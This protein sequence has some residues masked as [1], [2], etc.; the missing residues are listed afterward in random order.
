MICM[1]LKIPLPL[2]FSSSEPL[3]LSPHKNRVNPLWVCVRPARDWLHVALDRAPEPPRGLCGGIGDTRPQVLGS[4]RAEEVFPALNCGQGL[5]FPP[6][7]GWRAA[8]EVS[9]VP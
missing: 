9:L 3:N 5:A 8:C 2:G 7:A 4:R 1:G 6:T